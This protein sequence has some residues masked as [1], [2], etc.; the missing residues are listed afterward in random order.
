ME[1]YPFFM[2]RGSF[3]QQIRANMRGPQ[4]YT[5]VVIQFTLRPARHGKYFTRHLHLA[6]VGMVRDVDNL[7]SV[8][9]AAVIFNPSISPCRIFAQSMIK[10]DQR[11]NDKFPGSLSNVLETANLSVDIV[12]SGGVLQQPAA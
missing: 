7:P 9:I 2:N 6:A 3:S 5:R 12:R 8:A 1:A 10:H 4:G 11:L